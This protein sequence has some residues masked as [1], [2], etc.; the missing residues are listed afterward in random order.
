MLIKGSIIKGVYYVLNS[1]TQPLAYAK[2]VTDNFGKRNF[3][4]PKG[5]FNIHS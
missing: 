3:M 4:E 5:K 2:N 1:V